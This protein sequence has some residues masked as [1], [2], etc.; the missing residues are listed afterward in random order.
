MHTSD[1]PST[2]ALYLDGCSVAR[3]LHRS[4]KLSRVAPGVASAVA[5]SSASALGSGA[6]AGRGAG[7]RGRRPGWS[8][9]SPTAC[10]DLAQEV[11]RGEAA[12]TELA[13]QRAE[14][15]TIDTPR[16]DSSVSRRETSMVS[17]GSSSS[18]SS[19]HSTVW[20]DS[21]STA[22]VKPRAP[23]TWVTSTKVANDLGP[24]IE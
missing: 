15:A 22:L 16:A 10:V 3:C 14:V 7:S 21:R 17:P 24:G 9:R 23:T 8:R 1:T 11:L 18:N 6:A 13:G 4:S 19:M 5:I 2:S 12:L 20:F